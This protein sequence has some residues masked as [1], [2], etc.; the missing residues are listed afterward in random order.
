MPYAEAVAL[1]E[2]SLGRLQVAEKPL[3]GI[4]GVRIATVRAEEN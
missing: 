2:E 1:A 4:K 3:N